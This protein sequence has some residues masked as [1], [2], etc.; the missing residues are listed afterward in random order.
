MKA[1]IAAYIHSSSL[2]TLIV[3]QD[4]TPTHVP[5]PCMFSELFLVLQKKSVEFFFKQMLP[6]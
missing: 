6:S 3:G 1:P 2:A 4:C 5:L